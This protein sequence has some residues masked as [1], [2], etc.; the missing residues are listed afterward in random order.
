MNVLTKKVLEEM[1]SKNS[2]KYKDVIERVSSEIQN[3]NLKKGRIRPKDS[4][5]TKILDK[6]KKRSENYNN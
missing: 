4:I 6:F 1:V 5:E 3:R 2:I